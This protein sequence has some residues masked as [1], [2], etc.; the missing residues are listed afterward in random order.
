MF[1]KRSEYRNYSYSARRQLTLFVISSEK[2]II[3]FLNSN[4]KPLVHLMLFFNGQKWSKAYQIWLD[5]VC[6]LDFKSDQVPHCVAVAKTTFP[7]SRY[8]PIYLRK[9]TTLA[10]ERPN[11]FE[12]YKSGLKRLLW[13]T[14]VY[15]PINWFILKQAANMLL[16]L[17]GAKHNLLH[18]WRENSNFLKMIISRL[19]KI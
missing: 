5:L 14:V 15:E 11:A 12:F 4:Y 7:V 13:L 18:F 8:P 10:W 2:E 3:S 17:F 1:V 16:L 9:C 6:K 19:V